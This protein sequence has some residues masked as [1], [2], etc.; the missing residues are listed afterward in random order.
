M[1]LRTIDLQNVIFTTI[2]TDINVTIISLYLF[3]PLIIPNSDTQVMFIE[4]I[5]NNFTIT[6][7]SWYTECKLSTN[8]NEVQVDIGRAQHVFT[9]KF[10]FRSFQASDRTAA[11]NKNNNIA[12]FDNAIVKSFFVI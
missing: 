1:T 2:A 10:L 3:V 6:F 4:F 11:L 8:G 9:P 7:D 5:R 12:I